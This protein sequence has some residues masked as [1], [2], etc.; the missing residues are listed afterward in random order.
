[1]V[2]SPVAL[3]LR[4]STVLMA[5]AALGSVAGPAA[6]AASMATGGLT[7]QPIGHY[8]FCKNHPGECSIRPKNLAPAPMTTALWKQLV[9]VNAAVNA[10]V[11]PLSDMEIYGKDEVWAY[12]DKGVGDCEDYVLEKRR[13]LNRFGLSLADLL[14]TVVRKPDGEGHAVLTVRTSKGDFI[15]DNLTDKVRLWDETDYRYLK[16]QAMTNTGRWVSIRDDQQVLVG[17]VE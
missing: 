5:G 9:S 7:S 16:R 17:S 8:E 12:P 6:A 2:S 13:R 4:F 11:K 14:V 3:F 10:A 15:L 1:M